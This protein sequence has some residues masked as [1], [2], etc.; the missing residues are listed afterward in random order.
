MTYLAFF[1]AGLMTG[2][3]AGVLAICLAMAGKED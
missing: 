3:F 1:I 2:G